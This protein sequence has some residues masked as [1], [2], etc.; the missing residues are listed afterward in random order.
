MSP[1]RLGGGDIICIFVFPSERKSLSLFPR[2]AKQDKYIFTSR[3]KSLIFSRIFLI[4]VSA[5][6]NF[7]PY[8]NKPNGCFCLGKQNTL[9]FLG[10][11]RTNFFSLQNH[12]KLLIFNWEDKTK[13][14]F[15]LRYF[16]LPEIFPKQTTIQFFCFDP[17]FCTATLKPH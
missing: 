11:T 17:F 12:T 2:F 1:P 9:L 3:I 8:G 13:F 16:L 15:C 14:P 5:S 6:S 10:E 7:F 4:F